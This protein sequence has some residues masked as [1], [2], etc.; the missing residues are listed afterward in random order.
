MVEGN[1]IQDPNEPDQHGGDNPG[2]EGDVGSTGGEGAETA[3][4]TPQVADD[5]E[6]GQTTSPAHEGEVGVPDDEE[7]NRDPDE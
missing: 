4:S 2:V 5:T 3:S 6:A 1:P 7:M